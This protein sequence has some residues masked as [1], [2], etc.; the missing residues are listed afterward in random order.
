[1]QEDVPVTHE[2]N[3]DADD[4]HE[5]AADVDITAEPHTVDK[6]ISD[7]IK[8]ELP[9]E[10]NVRKIIIRICIKINSYWNNN[11]DVKRNGMP[12]VKLYKEFDSFLDEIFK[13]K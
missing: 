9:A 3:N 2:T 1:M 6:N 11:L 12:C 7:G 10:T 4:V 5:V 8:D 13:E